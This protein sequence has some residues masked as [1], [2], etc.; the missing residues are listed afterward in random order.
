MTL[1]L[2]LNY[3]ILDSADFNVEPPRERGAANKSNE[4]PPV[5]FRHAER[6]VENFSRAENAES[7][8]PLV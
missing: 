3:K 4:L 8:I 7:K 1:R 2:A 6:V 5:N